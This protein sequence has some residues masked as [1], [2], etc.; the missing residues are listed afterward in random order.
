MIIHNEVGWVKARLVLENGRQQL[1]EHAS[2]V[3]SVDLEDGASIFFPGEGVRLQYCMISQYGLYLH[4][5]PSQVK[6]CGICGGQSGTGAGCLR[7]LLFPLPILIPPT[8]HHSSSSI[9][10][11]WYNRPSSGLRTKWTQ[12]HPT[13]RNKKKILLTVVNCFTECIERLI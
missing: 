11:G 13:P 8:A 2:S 12:S 3:F 1:V 10:R 4:F 5:S 9:I 7:V 6:S